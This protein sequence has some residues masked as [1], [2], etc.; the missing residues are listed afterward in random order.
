[1]YEE[2]G[3]HE[4]IVI[5]TRIMVGVCRRGGNSKRSVG[6]VAAR[7][8]HQR[9]QL[10]CGKRY[11]VQLSDRESGGVEVT[12]TLPRMNRRAIKSMAGRS[13]ND[14]DHYAC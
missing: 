3:P 11:G 10:Y 13:K 5:G 14:E 7:N 12:I 6:I 1:M 8:V 2:V 4:D 9:I